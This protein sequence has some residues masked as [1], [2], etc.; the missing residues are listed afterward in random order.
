[1]RPPLIK[2]AE[3]S[4]QEWKRKTRDALNGVIKRLMGFGPTS[5][6]PAGATDGQMYYDRTLK[7]PIWWNTADGEWKDAGG[8]A[9]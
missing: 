3:R 9:A 7:K 2:E 8:T 6:R 4:D 1:M 5:E